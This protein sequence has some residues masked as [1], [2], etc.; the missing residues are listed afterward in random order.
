MPKSGNHCIT[1]ALAPSH[2]GKLQ[3]GKPQYDCLNVLGKHRSSRGWV[4]W[5]TF[6]LCLGWSLRSCISNMLLTDANAVNPGL[7]CENHWVNPITRILPLL[8]PLSVTGPY[9]AIWTNYGLEC[10]RDV[11]DGEGNLRFSSPVRKRVN[12]RNDSL[13]CFPTCCMEIRQ[14]AHKQS[15]YGWQGHKSRIFP[16]TDYIWFH[17]AQNEAAHENYY[18]SSCLWVQFG[19]DTA[20]ELRVLWQSYTLRFMQCVCA[21][22]HAHVFVSESQLNAEGILISQCSLV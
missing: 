6:W 8:F 16:W 1:G 4:Y 2:R 5:I 10:N 11:R 20:A 13:C 22:A 7:H 15:S 3:N 9:R 18:F 17:C 19:E 12:E 14:P 21:R